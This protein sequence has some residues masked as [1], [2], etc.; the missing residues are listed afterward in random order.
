MSDVI[1][2]S[3]QGKRQLIAL[4]R[5]TKIDQWNILCRWALCTSLQDTSPI[6]NLSLGPMSNV[7]MTWETFA[8]KHHSLFIA[9]LKEKNQFSK[10]KEEA[11]K[12]YIAQ[13]LVHIHRG[14]QILA[15]KKP[16]ISD[17]IKT[18]KPTESN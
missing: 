1:R 11:E 4:K 7:E 2:I 3:E 17:L 18:A 10:N 9:L 6:R 15:H 16:E 8:G 12:N 13:A 14:I 5:S